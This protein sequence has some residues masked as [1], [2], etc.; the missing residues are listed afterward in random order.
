MYENGFK[1]KWGDNKRHLKTSQ[2]WTNTKK[3]STNYEV[4]MQIIIKRRKT[5]DQKKERKVLRNLRVF[6][7]CCVPNSAGNP[8]DPMILPIIKKTNPK[9]KLKLKLCCCCTLK[10]FIFSSTYNFNLQSLS[11]KHQHHTELCNNEIYFFLEWIFNLF[12][13]HT[14]FKE[15]KEWKKKKKKTRIET[16]YLKFCTKSH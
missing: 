6:E 10:Y 13:I 9:T 4:F 16:R 5:K 12:K 15:R 2:S 14:I 1:F 3:N 7:L 11:F 8:F